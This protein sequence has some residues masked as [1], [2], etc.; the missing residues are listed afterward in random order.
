MPAC[1]PTRLPACTPGLVSGCKVAPL[2][3]HHSRWHPPLPVPSP[4]P[5]CLPAPPPACC[6]PSAAL[7]MASKLCGVRTSIPNRSLMSQATQANPQALS[8]F[9]LDMLTSLNWD[10]AAVLRRAGLLCY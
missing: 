4:C 1:L 9:E 2:L 10:A 7:W 6:L 8:D 3:L 5:A